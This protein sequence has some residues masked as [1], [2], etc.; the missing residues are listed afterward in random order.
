MLLLATH[1]LSLMAGAENYYAVGRNPISVDGRS[2]QQSLD[3]REHLDTIGRTANANGVTI[4][5]FFPEGL[6][7]T[8]TLS[9]GPTVWDY[10]NLYNEVPALVQIAETTGGQAAW[11][12]TDI[13]KLLPR[14]RQDLD[15]YYSLAYHVRP[16]GEDKA[17]DIVVKAKNRELTVRARHEFTDKSDV[18]RMEDRVIAA[19]FHNPPS[20]G[21]PLTWPSGNAG[22]RENSS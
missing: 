15:S 10:R 11:G 1:R 21:F 20:T 2:A 3:M 16:R 8:S 7:S 14:V 17:R 18:T 4:Y 6:Q 19:L 13:E 12:S 22:R 5:P 9:A